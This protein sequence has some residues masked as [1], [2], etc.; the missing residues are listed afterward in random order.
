MKTIAFLFILLPLAL[1]SQT[2]PAPENSPAKVRWDGQNLTMTYNGVV[3]LQGRLENP[4]SLDYYNELKDLSDQA[5]SQV[6]QF[7]SR[8]EPL[9][10][11]C[12]VYGSPESF[13]C[14]AERREDAPQIIRHSVGQSHSLLN[15]AVYDRRFDWLL[16]A[17]FP[18]DIEITPETFDDGR[19]AYLFELTGYSLLLRF[20]PH[21]YQYHKGLEYF[22]PWTYPIK[23]GSVAGWCSWFAFYNKVTEKDIHRTADVLSKVLVPFG[24][25]YLQIDDGYQQV[26]IGEPER[27]LVPNDKFPSGMESLANY[28]SGKGMKP[29]IWTNVSFAHKEFVMENKELFVPDPNN[30]PAYGNWVGYV[31]DGSNNRTIEQLITPVYAG[32]RKMGWHYFKLDAL[33]HLRYEGYNSY[34]GY[35][36]MWNLDRKV[37]FRNVVQSVREAISWDNYLMACW[38]LR[39]ELIGIVDACR[40]GDD[41]FGFGGLAEYNSF[42]NVVWRNDPDHIELTPENAYRSCMVTSLTGSLFMLTDKPEVYQTPLVEAAKRTIPILFTRPGQVYEVDPSSIINLNKANSEV[43]GG[44]PR[45]F[46]AD[47]LEYCHLYL[48]EISKPFE[49]WMILGRTGALEVEDLM[50]KVGDLGLDADKEYLVFEFWTKQFLGVF[51]NELVFPAIDTTYKCQALCIREKQGHPQVLATNRHISCGGYDLEN[52]EWSSNALSGTSLLTG[53]DRYDIYLYEPAGFIFKEFTCDGAKVSGN[54]KDGDIRIVSL[55][56]EDKGRVSWK[57]GY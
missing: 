48:Q 23:E 2:F 55:T 14:E 33:R 20:R 46:D 56:R 13:P 45:S 12:T 31:M 21:Y 27:W 26:P 47:Q 17:D 28:I 49:D 36:A 24:L 32:F 44:G 19:N 9:R 11:T 39:P 10:M 52:V 43:S 22:E 40:I 29:G 16:S 34:A 50:L 51:T 3:L 35:F 1:L 4:E 5:V 18:T 41:G 15:R 30:Q 37:V 54:R 8:K 7:V 57:A 25:E 53:K 6:V 38:G 42:N